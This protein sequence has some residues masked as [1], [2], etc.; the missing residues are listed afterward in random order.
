MSFTII[1]AGCEKKTDEIFD[2]TPDERLVEALANYQQALVGAPNGWK[3]MIFPKGLASQDIEVGG[4]SFYMKF[5][6]ANR[7]TMFSDF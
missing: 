2:K 1:F 3:V 5:T 7:V 6:N 4:F